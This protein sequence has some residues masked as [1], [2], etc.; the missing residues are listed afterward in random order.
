MDALTA[1]VATVAENA[2]RKSDEQKSELKYGAQQRDYKLDSIK[3]TADTDQMRL[4]RQMA[5]QT[6]QVDR[7]IADT[8]RI[9]KRNIAMVEKTAALQ[10]TGKSS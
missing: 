5:D 7:A 3:A 9:S 8:D 10:G 6:L 2:K 1:N 4:D